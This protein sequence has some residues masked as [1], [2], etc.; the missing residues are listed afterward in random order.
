MAIV[1][2]VVKTIYDAQTRG[3]EQ[4]VE[5]LRDRQS[6][7]AAD[8]RKW[9][10]EDKKAAKERVDRWKK[11]AIGIGTAAAAVLAA[12]AAYQ[13]YARE[14]SL[15]AA[16][17]AADINRLSEAAGGLQTRMQLLEFAA[18]TQAGA[19]KLTTEEMVIAQKAI[20]AITNSGY[21][22]EEATKKVTDAI[23][24]LNGGGLAEFGIRVRSAKTDGEKFAAVLDA[25]AQ[26]AK[27]VDG[28]NATTADSIQQVG[29]RFTDSMDRIKSALGQIVIAL[30]P[31]IAA[32][33]KLTE[34]GSGWI[35]DLADFTGTVFGSDD[36][37]RRLAGRYGM[38]YDAETDSVYDNTALGNYMM[39]GG[40]AWDFAKGQAKNRMRLEKLREQENAA[41]RQ[42]SAAIA[43]FDEAIKTSIKVSGD[44]AKQLAADAKKRREEA[45]KRAQELYN[46]QRDLGKEIG[47]W[48]T[49]GRTDEMA[50]GARS[51]S[52]PSL[53]AAADAE[54]RD[55][56][57]RPIDASS[58][59]NLQRL[60]RERMTADWHARLGAHRKRESGLAQM[61]G[62]LEEFNAYRT[63]FD[64]LSGAASSALGAWIDGSMSAGQAFKKF[65]GDSLAALSQQLLVES[66]KHGAYAI[67]SLIPGPFFNPGGAAGHAA[68]AA[69]FAGGAGL[70]AIAARSL[71]GGGA[72]AGAGGGAGAAVGSSTGISAPGRTPSYE[73]GRHTTIIVGD[74]LS[75]DSPRYRRAKLERQVARISG[76][77]AGVY[78]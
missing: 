77:S 37:S 18:K 29:V 46:L 21:D 55:E 17:G 57:G 4:G 33:A 47:R 51:S 74:P 24:K 2:N 58:S 15:V 63:A 34:M 6:A 59:D 65:I 78:A 60:N 30:E 42:E 13:H 71:G 11:V 62:P 7:L 56:Y 39:A 28:A 40:N 26:K 12:R 36:A 32:A 48:A 20:R 31:V 70:A 54:I 44:A 45:R 38:G 10:E 9:D 61:F 43:S 22:Q 8:I 67:A 16:A 73:G 14:Q 19:F 53:G 52:A 68:A 1:T 25:L 75:D 5:R 49:T 76:T 64:T 41:R 23:V 69:A 72:A 35:A 50:P 27:E 3:H 66:L